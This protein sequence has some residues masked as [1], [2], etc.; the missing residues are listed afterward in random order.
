[1]IQKALQWIRD[2]VIEGQG[3]AVSSQK[4]IAYPE[5]TGYLIPTLLSCGEQRLA[6]NFAVWLC[7]AQQADGSFAPPRNAQGYAFD[8]GQVIRGWVAMLR[9]L[10]ELER[11]LRRACDWL[12]ATAD[13]QTARLTVP[14][15]GSFWS[16]GRRG[17]INEGI[18]LYAL[19]PLLQ[20]GETLNEPRYS[21]FVVRS[22]DYYLKN[23]N[24]TD[25]GQPNAL[26]HFFAYIQEALLDLGC[27]D[28][29]RKGM[30]SVAVC[31]QAG[32]AVPAYSDVTWVCSTGLAQLAQVWYR[33]ME[34]QRADAAMMALA[35]MQNPSG[36]F[37][38]SYGPGANYFATEEIPWAAKYAIEASQ[39]Q[40]CSHFD[41][42][43]DI[44]K[45]TIPETD[46]RVQAICRHLGDLAG[47]RVLDAGCGKGRYAGLLKQRFPSAQITA[48]DISAAMLRHVSQGIR[49]VQHG[50]L[51]M[52]FPDGAFDAVICVEALE[53]VVHIEE[54]VKEL[55]RV[56]APQGTLIVID[57][58]KDK[59]GALKM[60]AWEKWFSRDELLDM[61][62]RN[63]L[64]AQAELVGYNNVTEPDGLF[65]CWSGRKG[66]VN[67][68]RQNSLGS[69]L[70]SRDVASM[71][72]DSVVCRT[73]QCTSVSSQRKISGSLLVLITNY[74]CSLRCRDCGNFIPY[75]PPHYRKFFSIDEMETDLILLSAVMHVEHMLLQ[76]GEPL[77]HPHLDRVIEV[78]VRS[79]IA[80]QLTI[81]TNATHL[82]SDKVVE[83][84][85]RFGVSIRISDYG[86][87]KQKAA[88]LIEQCVEH[89]IQHSVY[90]MAPGDN[91]WHLLGRLGQPKNS[92][93]RQVGQ[94][95]Q[96][97]PYR[98]YW[99]VSDGFFTR[100]S[101]SPMGHLVGLHEFFPQDF[102]AIRSEPMTLR[103]RLE[104]LLEIPFM[105]TCRYC[106]GIH[107]PKIPPGIQLDQDDGEAMQP[108]R[109]VMSV[110]GRPLSL[111]IRSERSGTVGNRV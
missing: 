45:A 40:I 15:A 28:E 17:E 9:H 94:I 23:V 90:R 59:L 81:V 41:Q 10:P 32:G 49:T 82:L 102:V 74:P 12:I 70:T 56:L 37:F 14:R 98:S 38:G 77:L 60:P 43:V 16:L 5:V 39:R 69:N 100:C 86:A 36:G 78:A 110:S 6:E 65:L 47:K 24:L 54:G 89:G 4:K 83:A 101:R 97:C 79:G 71:H 84:C 34:T 52:P 35:A 108:G 8:T 57:K 58:N 106:N 61:M 72:E 30:A 53:H 109:R 1:M 91:T 107:G 21:R 18:H 48:M 95:H 13:P 7:D 3:A 76:G 68:D 73:S 105:E 27:G 67:S 51:D 75:V 85:H 2:H 33:L 96:T 62:G 93:D 104:A 92:D 63:G 111:P 80:S 55:A 44:Y 29:A 99:T 64:N 25:F 66:G 103:R 88:A 19:A 11:P 31:Q 42:T 46:G 50:I 22:L 26:T 87:R 20:A